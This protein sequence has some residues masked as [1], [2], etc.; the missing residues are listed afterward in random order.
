MCNVPEFGT[1]PVYRARTGPVYRA[2]TDP[3][4]LFASPTENQVWRSVELEVIA[5]PLMAPKCPRMAQA[6]LRAMVNLHKKEPAVHPIM[7]NQMQATRAIVR[8]LKK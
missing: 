7:T 4:Y 2:F 3:V 8:I 1:G 5:V 6:L